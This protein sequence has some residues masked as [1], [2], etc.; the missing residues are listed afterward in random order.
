[1]FMPE[2]GWT[3]G[4]LNEHRNGRKAV[5]GPA[6]PRSS[7]SLRFEPELL[8]A[9]EHLGNAD[10]RAAEAVPVP[11]PLRRNSITRAART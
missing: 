9:A 11:M 4:F 5:Y 7:A 10:R 1:M 3:K 8:S 2:I 6:V